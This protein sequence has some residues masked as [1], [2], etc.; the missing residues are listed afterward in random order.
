MQKGEI[1]FSNENIFTVEAKFKPQKD[2]VLARHVAADML[3]V[4]RCQNQASVMFWAAVSKTL[5]SP[6][7]FLKQGAKVNTNVYFNV[8]LFPL[9]RD[10]KVHFKNED[11]IFQQDGAPSHTSNKTEAWCRENFL[12]FWSKELWPP[13]LSIST[14][15]T[16]DLSL[17]T[18]SC[19]VFESVFGERLGQNTAEKVACSY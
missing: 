9:L 14:Q 4:Y 7:N 8:I 15:W 6:L 18:P 12:K 19:E 3:T 11:F 1:V 10:M 5:K 17:S 2:R 16:S 13:S